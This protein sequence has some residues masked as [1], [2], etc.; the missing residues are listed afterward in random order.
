MFKN[1]SGHSCRGVAKPEMYPT[2]DLL[3]YKQVILC[4]ISDNI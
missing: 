2:T 4:I 3:S 1:A